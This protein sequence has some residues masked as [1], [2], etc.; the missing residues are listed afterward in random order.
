M[1]AFEHSPE[2]GL[3]CDLFRHNRIPLILNFHSIGYHSPM[4]T[5]RSDELSRERKLRELAEKIEK[6]QL[7]REELDNIIPTQAEYGALILNLPI[8]IM[9]RMFELA[10]EAS[11]IEGIPENPL[12]DIT[13]SHVCR[14]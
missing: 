10:R 2:R 7:E 1:S 6:L 9:C 4:S 8:E 12:I 13:I 11:F 5:V 3:V 14:Q